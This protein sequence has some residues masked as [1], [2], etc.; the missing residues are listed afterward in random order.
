MYTFTSCLKSPL[1]LEADFTY[2][3]TELQPKRSFSEAETSIRRRRR[4]DAGVLA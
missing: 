4:S 2:A 3:D 1:E